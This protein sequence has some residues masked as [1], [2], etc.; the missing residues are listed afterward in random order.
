M[1]SGE[2][3]DC[4]PRSSFDS[5]NKFISHLEED[6]AVLLLVDHPRILA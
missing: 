5:W 2:A 1:K 6:T 4:E 3:G